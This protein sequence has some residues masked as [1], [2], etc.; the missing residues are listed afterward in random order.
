[1]HSA[2]GGDAGRGG[3]GHRP[4]SRA[5]VGLQPGLCV[6]G[7][8]DSRA[9]VR[10]RG[11]STAT[12]PSPEL[13][14]TNSK[15]PFTLKMWLMPAPSVLQNYSSLTTPSETPAAFSPPSFP[16][17]DTLRNRV[18]SAHSVDGTRFDFARPASPAHTP[19]C[20]LSGGCH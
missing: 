12:D 8:Q 3:G 13:P 2:S 9:S 14:G 10:G 11:L 1:M 7:F 6:E 19:D 17:L 18:H 4:E 5:A 20:L 15:Y 16:C